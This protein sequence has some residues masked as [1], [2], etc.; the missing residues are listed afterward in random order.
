LQERALAPMLYQQL[1]WVM[2]QFTQHFMQQSNL[3][4]YSQALTAQAINF[5]Q[6]Q[7]WQVDYLRIC[8]ADTLQNVNDLN[9]NLNSNISIDANIHN[10]RQL[11]ILVAAKLGF[12]RLIDN[13][14]FSV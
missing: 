1:Q 10:S 2:L 13:L 4:Q 14:D 6:A 8:Y 11:V 9:L 5:L 3:Q 7:G 12:T